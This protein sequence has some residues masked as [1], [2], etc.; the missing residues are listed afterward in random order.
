MMNLL[1]NH[2]YGLQISS[3]LLL[4]AVTIFT[5]IRL[6]KLEGEVVLVYL[7]S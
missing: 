7:G 6:D 5:K 1:V 4:V 3:F 2:V